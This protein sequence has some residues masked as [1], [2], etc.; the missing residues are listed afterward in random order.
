MLNHLSLWI[1]INNFF[2]RIRWI[3]TNALWYFIIK[4]PLGWKVFVCLVCSSAWGLARGNGLCDGP[5]A[6]E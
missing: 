4:S 2:K 3:T 1:D 5:T 6:N